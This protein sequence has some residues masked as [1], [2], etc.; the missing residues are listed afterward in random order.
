M[1]IRKRNLVFA[2]AALTALSTVHTIPSIA[3]EK[4]MNPVLDKNLE[5]NK[6]NAVGFYDLMFNKSQ[7][8]LAIEQYTGATYIQHN[9][10]VAD[11][12]EAFISYFEKMAKEYPNKRVEFVRV[13]A[14]GNYVVLHCHQVWPGFRDADW[15]GMDI[16][17]CDDQGKIVEHWDVLQ[18]V[19]KRMA[20]GNGMF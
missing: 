1:D 4:V 13:I 14:E 12:K 11:G 5:R 7:P 15:A 2:S 20:H 17:R 8:R 16:F 19:P 9:P 3:Q 18:T 10:E 6:K